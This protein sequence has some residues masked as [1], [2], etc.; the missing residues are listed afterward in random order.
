[1]KTP[2]GTPIMKEVIKLN[3]KGKYF[4]PIKVYAFQPLKIAL[5]RI[6]NRPGIQQDLLR[7]MKHYENFH[8]VY[9]GKLWEETNDCN[10]EIFF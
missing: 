4:Y 2:C 7:P 6:I 10:G 1:M 8:D 9:E 3:G 5:E